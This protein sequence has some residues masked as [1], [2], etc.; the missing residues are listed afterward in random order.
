MK[1]RPMS[2]R[3][4][5]EPVEVTKRNRKRAAAFMKKHYDR[6]RDFDRDCQRVLGKLRRAAE[7]A[8]MKIVHNMQS[9][10]DDTPQ[11]DWTLR[12]RLRLPGLWV[13]AGEGYKRAA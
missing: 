7:P 2:F 4:R 11:P 10:D 6:A 8:T 9:D 3:E 5:Q 12:F 13:T 1:L